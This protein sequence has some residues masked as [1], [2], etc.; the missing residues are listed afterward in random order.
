MTIEGPPARWKSSGIS[1]PSKKVSVWLGFA[2]RTI[3][4]PRPNG[5]RATPGKFWITRTG[6]PKVPGIF[7]IS[8][9]E[10]VRRT[11]SFFSFVSRTTVWYPLGRGRM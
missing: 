2:P 1:T 11:T 7:W 6:S 8:A 5:A 4:W 3:S 9:R 10:R